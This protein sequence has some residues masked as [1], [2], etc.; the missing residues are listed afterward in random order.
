[1]CKGMRKAVGR[2]EGAEIR[3]LTRAGEQELCG[4]YKWQDV[5]V[6]LLPSKSTLAG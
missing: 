6:C 3:K 1:M 5:L 4:A 2:V